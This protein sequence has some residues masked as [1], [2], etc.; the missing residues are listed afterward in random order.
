MGRYA[1]SPAKIYNDTSVWTL[2]SDRDSTRAT[3]VY[4]TYDDGRYVMQARERA[5]YPDRVGDERHFIQLDRLAEDDYQWETEVHHA[6]GQVRPAQVAA[7]IK[8]LFTGFE[9]RAGALVLGDAG[10]VFPRAARHMTQLIAVDTLVTSPH[11]DGSTSARYAL[12][13]RPDSLR[14]RYPNFAAYLGKYVVP[15]VYR[16]QLTD[17]R[18]GTYLD[19]SGRDGRL[20]VNLRARQ[21]VL[22]PLAGGAPLPDS[23]Q[24]LM[25]FSAKFGLFRVGFRN[26]VA[27]F[28][29]E[30]GEHL[31]AWVWHF[32]K[33]PEWHFP[34]AMD[35]LIK[36]PLRRPFDGAGGELRLA[37]RDD[38]G[39]QTM[40]ARHV[41]LLVRES[42]IMRWLSGLGGSAFGE[43]QE[44]TEAEENRF[45]SELFAAL[46][47]D[48]AAMR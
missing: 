45:L 28:A 8:T 41:R 13:F 4:G 38:L 26:L 7:V 1:L 23:L 10:D 17:G 29:I 11:A 12:R 33:E 30:R 19:A 14:Q 20:V 34:L 32:R 18:G 5:G 22:V 46:R 47:A 21:G 44:K 42:T 24:M 31:N 48:V 15:A 39:A 6:V 37:V 3:Y 16:V 25:D 36:T 43:F 35:K 2:R 27:D 9:G 40:S